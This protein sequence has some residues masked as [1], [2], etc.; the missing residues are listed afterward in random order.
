MNRN[1]KLT[2]F[3]LIISASSISARS[4]L[5]TLAS[6]LLIARSEVWKENNDVFS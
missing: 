4:T 3:S 2:I 1:N 5:D 6:V